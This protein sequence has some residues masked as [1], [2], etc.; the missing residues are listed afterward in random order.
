MT[1][2][3]PAGV[4][5]KPRR[6]MPFFARHPWVYAQSVARVVGS[7]SAGDEVDVISQEGVFI[8]RGLFNPTSKIL[9][10][11]YRW[12]E[13]PLDAAFWYARLSAA[14]LVRSEVLNLGKEANAYRL[15]FSEG[16]DLSGLTVDR[17]DRWLVAEF[18]SVAL[19]HRRDEFLDQLMEL[20]GAE[21][22]LARTD[23]AIAAEEGLRVQDIETRGT[24]PAGPIP[25]IEN[26]VRYEV[27]LGA[28]Q[29][30]GFYF[31]QRDNRR[32]VAR[33]CSGKRV[34]D[35]CCF[36][37]GF[38]LGALR[39][40]GAASTLGLD[41]SA[42]AV[43]QAAHN[44]SLNGLDRASF[45]SGDVFRVLEQ[46]GEAGER[47][48]VV[49]CDP[50]KYARHTGDVPAALKVIAVSICGGSSSARP[51]GNP[52]VLLVLG[53]AQPSGFQR[54]A[55]AFGRGLRAADPDPRAA[56]ASARSPDLG[57]MP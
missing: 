40:G 5:L 16:D 54:A 14:C 45:E 12:S 9:V 20:T 27:N 1:T 52:G 36:T 46:L 42:P 30:T 7:P 26:G 55:R 51:G 19:F 3:R 11:L 25:I 29:K 17:F 21:G 50:P 32:A 4:V 6:V 8:A 13:E 48:E 23:R 31:D 35:L 33:Y 15:V 37:G 47:F 28:G 39:L 10:R 57:L 49:I 2:S 53:R 34:L 24:L 41:S 43:A 38:S 44:A 18:S 56:R 22:I